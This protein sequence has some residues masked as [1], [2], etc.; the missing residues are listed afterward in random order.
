LSGNDEKAFRL[1]NITVVETK[2]SPIISRGTTLLHTFIQNKSMHSFSTIMPS[3]DNGRSSV[4]PYSQCCFKH[5]APRRVH[6]TSHTVSHQSTALWSVSYD[7]YFSSLLF[8]I[9]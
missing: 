2:D 5:T 1:H 3:P 8:S 4:A 7:Y 6:H 9:I